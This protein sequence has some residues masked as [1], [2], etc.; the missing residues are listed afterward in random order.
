[1]QGCSDAYIHCK[2]ELTGFLID[3]CFLS[4]QDN[5]TRIEP[6]IIPVRVFLFP[7]FLIKISEEAFLLQNEQKLLASTDFQGKI[8]MSTDVDIDEIGKNHWPIFYCAL[9]VVQ[10]IYSN[11]TKIKS[12]SNTEQ[13]SSTD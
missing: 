7:V 10:A 8:C 2:D 1:M 9:T 13:T 12:L 6:C 3:C 5:F 11:F 4:F